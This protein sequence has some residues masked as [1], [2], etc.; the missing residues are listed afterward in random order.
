MIELIVAERCTDC[1]ACIE[2]CPANVLDPGRDGSPVL[3]RVEDCQTCFMCE[4]YCRADAIYVAP[5]CDRRVSV[6]KDEVLASGR[7]GQ[8]RKHS[9]WDEWAEHFPNEQWLMETVFRRAGEAAAQ[10]KAQ[11]PGVIGGK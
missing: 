4:L 3:A 8:Y 11:K 10:P 5:D 2:V 1:G 7:L 6:T 9:G